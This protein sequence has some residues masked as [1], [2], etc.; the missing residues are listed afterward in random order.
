ML[1]N[2]QIRTIN[3]NIGNFENVLIKKEF[4]TD[5]EV[6]K[7]KASEVEGRAGVKIKY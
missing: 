1:S 4:K 6:V 7:K 3:F 5:I 2:K